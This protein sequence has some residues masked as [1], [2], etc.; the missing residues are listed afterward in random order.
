LPS[1]RHY[2]KRRALN[3]LSAGQG[4]SFVSRALLIEAYISG[5]QLTAVTVVADGRRCRMI[6]PGEIAPGEKIKHQFFFR[7]SHAELVHLTIG[8]DGWIDQQPAALA[9][10]IERTAA[11]LGAPYSS[12]DELR[13]AAEV[14]VAEI[15]ARVKASNQA[16]G[17]KQINRQYKAYRQAQMAKAEK[18]VPYAKFIEPFVATMVRQVAAT[19]RMI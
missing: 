6:R 9:A 1:A 10:L 12:P 15:T 8:L 14:Q 16:G 3:Y 13:R 5:L 17:L 18:A 2:D 7:P 4:E 11:N 19:G